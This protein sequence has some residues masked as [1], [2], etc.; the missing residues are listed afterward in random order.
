MIQIVD[1]VI[2]LD[3]ILR[4]VQDPSA[5]AT[6]LFVG[7]ARNET[8]GKKVLALEYEAHAQMATALMEKIAAQAGSTWRVTHISMI[9]R[10]GRVEIGEASVAVAVSSP[11]RREA[12]EACRYCID[13]LKRDVPIWKKEYFAGGAV[14]SEGESRK[15]AS[16][17][18]PGN[19]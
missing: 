10:I 19:Q 17:Q 8:D 9:H 13:T 5:G 2:D 18:P 15:S 7:T 11:H 6:A 4:S 1:H 12:F 3:E 16:P 14:W